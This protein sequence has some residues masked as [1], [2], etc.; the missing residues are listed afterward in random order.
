[1]NHLKL[2]TSPSITLRRVDQLFYSLIS[3]QF[4]KDIFNLIK[5]SKCAKFKG[6][7]DTIRIANTK[8]TQVTNYRTL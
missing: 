2:D 1:M 5:L 6:R 7:N 4:L 3:V 8:L